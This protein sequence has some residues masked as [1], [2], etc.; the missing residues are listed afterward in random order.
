[1]GAM[2]GERMEIHALLWVPGWEGGRWVQA[3]SAAGV[4]QCLRCGA[5]RP[6]SYRACPGCGHEP[7]DMLR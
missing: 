4:R 1:V 6:A 7:P 2:S 5:H 3:M